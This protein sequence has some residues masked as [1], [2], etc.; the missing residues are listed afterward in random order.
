VAGDTFHSKSSAAERNAAIRVYR[1][2]A[3]HFPVIVVKG[4]NSHDG[5][6]E[7]AFLSA[8]ETKHEIR[9]FE[10]PGEY[11]ATRVGWPETAEV[12]V[13]CLPFPEKNLLAGQLEPGQDVSQVAAEAL[14]AILLGWKLQFDEYPGARI[15]LG[16]VELGSAMSDSGQ[17]M[18]GKCCVEM[19]DG[20][21]LDAEADYYAL[22]HIHKHQISGD[23]RICYAGSVRQCTFGEDNIKGYC[24]VDVER[25]KLPVI[26][27]R[28]A[29]GRELITVEA[30]WYNNTLN[31]TGDEII[32]INEL[33]TEAGALNNMMAVPK[34]T[35]V[36][37]KYHVPDTDREQATEQAENAKKRWLEAGAHSVKLDM[38][39]KATYRVRSEAI[40]EAQTNETKLGAWWDSRGDRPDREKSIKKKLGEIESEV[41]T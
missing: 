35:I 24:L 38:R 6:G 15:L 39:A 28:R 34:G 19:S 21:L 26:E 33:H 22:G 25:G 2:W 13:A 37:L 12:M 10:R 20:D 18:V 5:P 32:E 27:H 9:V 4:N 36:R 8:L 41:M 3:N 29:P 30:H 7:I 14:R 1:S 23:G 17:P 16:H 11:I 40:R 31:N